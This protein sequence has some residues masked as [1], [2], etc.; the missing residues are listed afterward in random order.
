MYRGN[1]FVN[2]YIYNSFIIRIGCQF[3]YNL[4]SFD[5]R[6]KQ[7]QYADQ[8]AILTQIGDGGQAMYNIDLF[9]SI[10]WC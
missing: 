2:Y 4:I 8:Y 5:S 9:Q 6:M 1:F 3:C 7:V 10:S